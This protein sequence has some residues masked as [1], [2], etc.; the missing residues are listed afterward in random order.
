METTTA[1]TPITSP[2]TDACAAMFAKPQK[3]HEWLHQLLG[4]WTYVSECSGEPGQPPQKFGGTETVKSLGG[5]WIV[6]EAEGEF[7]GGKSSMMITLGFD[8]KQ[9]CFVGTF[10][11]SMMT[12]L[13][14]YKGHLNAAGRVLTLDA[15]GPSFADP[16]KLARYQ[17]IIEFRS[18]DH[19]VLSSQALG[20]DGHWTCFM[21][22]HYHRSA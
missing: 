17:D 4:K 16:N 12:H 6:G 8:P 18:P 10:V 22:A 2:E 19:R 11:A 9:D 5:L 7:P 13:W 15:E 3:E 21:T 14:Q 20:E 1:P